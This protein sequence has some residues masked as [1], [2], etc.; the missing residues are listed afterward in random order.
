M[1]PLVKRLGAKPKDP[2]HESQLLRKGG[3]DS[4]REAEVD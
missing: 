4:T 2:A 1:A 3:K